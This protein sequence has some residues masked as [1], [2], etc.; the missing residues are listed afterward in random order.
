V[1]T[2]T[3]PGSMEGHCPHCAAPLDI[4]DRAQCPSCGSTVNSGDYDWV[5]AE[6][7]QESEWNVPAP[8]SIP[9]VDDLRTA[10]HSFSVQHIEDRTSV[11]FWRLRSAEF[12]G[13]LDYARPVV[14]PELAEALQPAVESK[15][16]QFWKQPAVGVVE[17]LRV[18]QNEEAKTDEI[19]VLVRWSG[20]QCEIDP[21]GG[22]H[23]TRPQS[24]YSDVFVL[25]RKQGVQSSSERT[26]SSASCAQCGA[27]IAATEQASCPYCGANLVDGKHDW[28]L[29]EIRPFTADL[30]LAVAGSSE[31]M[32]MPLQQV[33]SEL[34]LAVLAR[35]ALSDG[36]LDPRE[37]QMLLDLGRDRDLS[38]EQ[39]EAAIA[40]AQATDI[41]LP[42]PR[43][44][45]QASQW[46]S[47]IVQ[48]ALA[49]GKIT[50]SEQQLLMK[51][52]QRMQLAP[53]D[54]KLAINRQKR[55]AFQ[56]AKSVIRD[57]RRSTSS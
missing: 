11:M 53:E 23:V 2:L 55:E 37:R 41:E 4:V 7:T 40:A 13:K 34:S 14:S 30:Q 32:A 31:G 26:F 57:S 12:F 45:S 25:S 19:L 24:I 5:L 36:E 10:D 56:R 8:R 3:H 43:S 42:V 16:R 39:V 18:E 15:Q 20:I 51:F 47:Q 21:R 17:C 9:G 49:D 44:R 38:P 22:N 52:A 48:A 27:P 54:V 29:L 50:T 6:I 46:L 28:V 1:Q 33:Q 35:I